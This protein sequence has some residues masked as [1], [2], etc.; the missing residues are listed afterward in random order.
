LGKNTGYMYAKYI[1]FIILYFAFTKSFAQASDGMR[2]NVRLYPVQMLA[3]GKGFS[4]EGNA[5]SLREVQSVMISSP[6]GFQ[7]NAKYDEYRDL[8]NSP[9]NSR[10]RFDEYHLISHQKGVVQ[11]RYAINQE[12]ENAMENLGANRNDEPNFLILTLIS[13]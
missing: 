11:E 1:L 9:E 3:I 6:S 12:L 8:M 2:L 13:Q 7:L 10:E 5:S 4:D